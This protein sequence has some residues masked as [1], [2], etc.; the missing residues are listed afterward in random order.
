MQQ[1][2]TLT[3]QNHPGKANSDLPH[4]YT[5]RLLWNM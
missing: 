3:E 5:H 1:H 4:E 2:F